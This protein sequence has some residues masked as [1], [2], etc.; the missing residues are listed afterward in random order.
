MGELGK[1]ILQVSIEVFSGAV[2]NFFGQRW[3]S[4]PIKNWPIRLWWFPLQN[5]TRLKQKDIL[6]SA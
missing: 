1:V 6:S 4:P 5:A 3:L 2:E